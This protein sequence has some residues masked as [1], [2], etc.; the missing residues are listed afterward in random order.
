MIYIS[1][2]RCLTSCDQS[3]QLFIPIHGV[4][5]RMFLCEVCTEELVKWLNESKVKGHEASHRV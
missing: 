3:T 5:N 1:C 2:S 4:T